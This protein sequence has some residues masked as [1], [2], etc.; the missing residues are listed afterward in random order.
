MTSIHGEP[1]EVWLRNER[2]ARFVWRG[3]MYTVL[4]VRDKRTLPAQQGSGSNGSGALMECWLVD[5][6]P[7][8][9]IPATAYELCFD[10]G[11]ER[12]SLSRS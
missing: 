12:W 3:R 6:T 4:Y 9:G 7:V 1:V 11:Q 10:A 8:R 2:P 5:A